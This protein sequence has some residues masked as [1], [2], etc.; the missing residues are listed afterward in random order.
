MAELRADIVCLV[1]RISSAAAIP[2]FR[3]ISVPRLLH[4]DSMLMRICGSFRNSKDDVVHRISTRAGCMEKKQ[5]KK[6]KQNVRCESA[7][8]SRFFHGS[9]MTKFMSHTRR[10][11][12]RSQEYRIPSAK[13]MNERK[14]QVHMRARTRARYRVHISAMLNIYSGN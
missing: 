13:L 4:P 10:G 11:T 3:V 2:E 6:K 1:T 5:Q 8:Q 7:S 9:S 14:T 12:F